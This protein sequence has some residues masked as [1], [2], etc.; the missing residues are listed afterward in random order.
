MIIIHFVYLDEVTS[1]IKKLDLKKT[2][3]G[4]S[5]EMLRENADICAPILTD[6]F[7]D[8]IKDGAFANELN[9]ADRTAILLIENQ[10]IAP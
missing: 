7:N 2:T 8:C 5:T 10:L 9:L 3:T 1:E 6:I 4:I